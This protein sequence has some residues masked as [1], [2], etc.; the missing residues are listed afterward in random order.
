MYLIL[1]YLFRNVGFK[2]QPMAAAAYVVEDGFV[3][4]QWE[5]RPLVL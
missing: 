4:H 5:E 3:G 1:F 2:E